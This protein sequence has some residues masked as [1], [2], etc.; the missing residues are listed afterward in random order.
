M[1]ILTILAITLLTALPLK[2]QQL[3]GY[4]IDALSGDSI[5]LASVYY[6]GTKIA[7]VSGRN[8]N[9]AIVHREGKKLSFSAIGYKKHVITVGKS[10]HITVRLKPETQQLQEVTI[11]RHRGHYDRKHNP[12]VEMMRKVI[13]A[14]KQTDLKQRDYYQYDKYQKLTLA[15][16]DITPALLDSPKF[17]KKPW[18][19]QQVERCPYNDKLILPVS[20]EET[21]SKKLYRKEPHDEK[22]IVRG[23]RQTGVNEL[24]ET[25]DILNVVM[26]DVFTNVNIYD[27]QIRMLQY[28]FTSPIGKNAIGFYRYYIE[29]TLSV[30][31]D[32]CFHLHFLPNNLQDVGFRGDLYILADST[33][34]VKRCEMTIPKQTSVNFVKGMKITQEFSR[35]DDGTWALTVDDMF[36]ELVIMK[37][38]NPLAVIRNTRMSNYSF[39]PLPQQLFKGKRKEI[40]EADSKMRND[41][42]WS[43][44]RQVE[45]THSESQMDRFLDG[46]QKI[47]GFRYILIG[48]K[49]LIEN[50]IETS[51]K[52]HPSKFDI[53]P[54]NALITTNFIDGLRTRFGG[55][56]TANLDS[57]LFFAGYIAHGWKSHRTYYKGEVTWS[58]NKKQYSFWEF[59]QRTLTFMSTSDVMSPSDRFLYTDKDNFLAAFKWTKVD[60]MMFYN[61]QMISF[62]WEE[63][64]GLRASVSLKTE[65]NKACGELYFTPLSEPQPRGYSR[66]LRT[67]E[68]RIG[69]RLGLGETFVNTKQKRTT[70]NRDAPV[71]TLY[72]TFGLKNFL[73]GDYNYHLTEVG[74]YKRFW[75]NSWGKL[76]CQLK[77]GIQWSQVP[78]PLLIMPEANLSVLIQNNNRFQLINDMEFL[79]DRYM[80]LMVSWD[81]NGKLFNR[82][83]LIKKLKCRE[84]FSVKCLWGG[85]SDK[86]NPFL[87]KNTGNDRLMYFPETSFI[88]DTKKPYVE[89][90]V[91]I[92]NIFKLIHVEY[93]RRL[94]YTNLPTAHKQGF[95]YTMCLTF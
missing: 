17:K 85:L 75:L 34:Q 72:H 14:K 63:Y 80:S 71:F 13:A 19:V 22:T 67:T 79:N 27:D 30:A 47:K 89:V 86:N 33:W 38:I 7:A 37:F 25:G 1:R 53:S 21:V 62:D 73:G 52:G 61:R 55:T 43:Q 95:R 84:F 88:M 46:L 82:I 44:Y 36:T 31:G 8:G 2:A 23:E 16:N 93:V 50:S 28:P 58:F 5:A 15:V 83:P 10:N 76:D 12:A 39:D 29:D 59:P 3:T 91:G 41:D 74:I 81:L 94:T 24:F 68:L 49:A 92:H 20:V 56:T 65:E 64:W 40:H 77:G 26:N 66:Y 90:A 6:K 9:F 48:L 54:V 42:F 57:S 60:K 4:V 45:L 35:L 69:L 32:T 18:L 87:E 78:F 51:R 11:S 70:I